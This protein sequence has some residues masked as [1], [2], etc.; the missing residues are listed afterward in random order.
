MHEMKDEARFLSFAEDSKCPATVTLYGRDTLAV[1]TPEAHDGLKCE[2]A[3]ER[4]MRRFD[5][6]EL[7]FDSG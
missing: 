4:L 2:L 1:M 7:E 6:A 5:R 3:H